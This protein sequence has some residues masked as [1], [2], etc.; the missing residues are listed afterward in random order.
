GSCRRAWPDR[1][2]PRPKSCSSRL[3]RS[4]SSRT[5]WASSAR[6]E[7]TRLELSRRSTKSSP[8]AAA[9]I[10]STPASS[11]P[12]APPTG[13]TWTLR[14]I[15]SWGRQSEGLWKRSSGSRDFHLPAE[16][17]GDSREQLPRVL[18]RGG[19]DSGVLGRAA[20]L[21]SRPEHP[22]G[23]VLRRDRIEEAAVFVEPLQARIQ[24]QDPRR[25]KPHADPALA[26]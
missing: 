7:K 19:L 25:G 1:A 18:D 3:H 2:A 8:A 23:P 17:L 15:V 24:G 26:R 6:A 11:P 10:S 13:C 20:E 9:A 22:A 4:E 12:S 14:H 5:S 16:R 21:T